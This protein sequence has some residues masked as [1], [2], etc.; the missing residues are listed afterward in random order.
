MGK[1]LSITSTLY[2]RAS[3]IAPST[4]R[5]HLETRVATR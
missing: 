3:Y 4:V 5:A 2:V 1:V